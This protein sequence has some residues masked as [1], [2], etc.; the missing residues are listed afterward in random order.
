MINAKTAPFLACPFDGHAMKFSDK[1]VTC[2]NNHSF[3]VSKYGYVNM[4]TNRKRFHENIGDNKEMLLSRER[5]LGAGY[6]NFL[7]EAIKQIIITHLPRKNKPGGIS[8]ILEVGSGTAF[9]INNLKNS[10]DK[11][12]PDK[13]F[14]YFG[15]DISKTAIELSAKRYRD[16]TF[17]VADTYSNLPFKD[18]SVSVILNIF[19]PRNNREFKR[20]LKDDGLLMTVIPSKDH[21]NEL[22][23]KLGLLGIEEN[24]KEKVEHALDRS[25]K[26][27]GDSK[28]KQKLLLNSNA[29]MDLVKMGPN[30]E[31]IN[32]EMILK[33]QSINNIEVTTSFNLNIYRPK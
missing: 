31:Y 7:T 25:F 29:V 17:I 9:Y 19:S 26:K 3:N 32:D 33:I 2:D 28:Y 12:L 14:F 16:I 6:Y 22:I 10:L 18:K 24:K 23:N 21:L 27:L 20:I 4:L 8:G 11:L 30:Y 15:T 1:M 5:F 13:N